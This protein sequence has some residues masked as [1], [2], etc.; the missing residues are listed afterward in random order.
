[1]KY[2][3][4]AIYQ[5]LMYL[6]RS[7]GCHQIPERSFFIRGRQFPVCARCTGVLVGNVLAYAMFFVYRLPIEFYIMGCA[8]MF[9]DWYIQYIRIRQSTNIRRLITGIIGGY[10]LAT[11]YCLLIKNAIEM[12]LFRLQ[13]GGIK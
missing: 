1:M 13:I 3:R 12:I 2:N 11:L 6:G 4:E 10:S 7:S 9:V 8:V 5:K